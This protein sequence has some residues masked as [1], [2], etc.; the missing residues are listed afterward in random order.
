MSDKCHFC[1]GWNACCSSKIKTV[2]ATGGNVVL[3]AAP[4]MLSN[5]VAP[6]IPVVNVNMDE[7]R[8]DEPASA[9]LMNQAADR[10][11]TLRAEIVEI[12]RQL[13]SASS[14]NETRI[15]A[16]RRQVF[17]ELDTKTTMDHEAQ[18]AAWEGMRR[19]KEKLILNSTPSSSA[20]TPE[21][22]S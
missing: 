15:D 16:L 5:Y 13:S 3:N 9:E 18:M 7:L 22:E 2:S 11:E 21:T 10:I 1:G 8:T 20:P 19:L 17:R 4:E 12:K 6:T 14:N